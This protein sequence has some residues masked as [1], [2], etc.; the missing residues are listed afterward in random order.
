M[1]CN[2]D[3]SIVYLQININYFY[4]LYLFLGKKY[5]V[6]NKYAIKDKIDKRQIQYELIS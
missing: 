1:Q 3:F 5:A 4:G 6:L 2:D